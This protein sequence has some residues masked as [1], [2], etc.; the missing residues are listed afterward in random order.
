VTDPTGVQ[1]VLVQGLAVPIAA[2]GSFS[3]VVQLHQGLN[4]IVVESWNAAGDR[5]K[6]TLS[7]IEGTFAPEGTPIAGSVVARL[8][9]PALDALARVAETMVT[10]DK[11]ETDLIAGN[12]LVDWKKTVFG[13]TILSAVINATAARLGTP[14]LAFTPVAGA[15]EAHVEVPDV[16]VDLDA[17]S[18]GGIPW[19]ISG[20][21]TA[22]KATVVARCALSVSGGK[23]VATI[24]SCDVSF[25]N[26]ALHLNHLPDAVA[27][28]A[29]GIVRSRVETAIANQVKAKVPG[30]LEQAIDNT[31]FQKALLGTTIG[32]VL[33]PVSVDQ[34]ASGETVR[35]DADFMAAPIAGRPQR[36]S[37]GSLATGSIPT[38]RASRGL[39][40]QVSDDLLNRAGH[41]AWRG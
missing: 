2:G 6:R 8:D 15:V 4:T 13:K 5:S 23:L 24:Q 14:T 34:D 10:A 9:G 28:L 36:P 33:T 39:L 22:D 40:V 1:A 25:D 19:G 30:A 35:F 3:T 37:P 20:S 31:T 12:P 32:A 27:G 18:N 7:I 21:V 29:D 11:L 41:A 26:F 16:A 38:A 17:H